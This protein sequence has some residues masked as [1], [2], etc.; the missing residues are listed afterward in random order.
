MFIEK[1]KQK[2]PHQEIGSRA[3]EPKK[4]FLGKRNEAAK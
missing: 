4:D 3:Q 1:N 2:R